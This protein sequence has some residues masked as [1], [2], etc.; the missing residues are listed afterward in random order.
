MARTIYT[1]TG[2][3]IAL[4]E[5][6]GQGGEATIYATNHAKIQAV[7][8][9]RAPPSSALVDKLTTLVGLASNRFLKFCAFPVVLIRDRPDGRVIGYGMQRLHA[10][11]RPLHQ[12]YG[13]RDR[14]EYFPDSNWK[15]LIHMARNL[16]QAVALL[17]EV[18][19]VVGDLNPN[20][21]LV[22][23]RGELFVV[24]V[25]S[26]QVSDAGR[27]YRCTVGM[28]D[29][30]APELISRPLDATDRA[31]AHD[32]FVLAIL[33]FHLLNLG[34]HPFQ[35]RWASAEEFSFELAIGDHRYVYGTEA[36]RRGFA[37]PPLTLNVQRMGATCAQL[38]ERAFV[39]H[40]QTRPSAKEWVTVLEAMRDNT[41]VCARA[42]THLYLDDAL[43]CPWCELESAG[44]YL[45][46]YVAAAAQ[47]AQLDVDQL[48]REIC[49][50]PPPMPAV[51]VIVPRQQPDADAHR[52]AAARRSARIFTFILVALTLNVAVAYSVLASVLTA[53]VVNLMLLLGGLMSL[54]SFRSMPTT[55]KLEDALRQSVQQRDQ[56]IARSDS[57]TVGQFEAKRLE[58]KLLCDVLRNF[59]TRRAGE[60]ARLNA[61]AHELQLLEFLDR[62]QILTAGIPRLNLARMAILLGNGVDTAKEVSYERLVNLRAI[63]PAIAQQLVEWR[64]A[65][66]AR[67]VFDAAGGAPRDQISAL[68]ADLYLE[69]NRVV[70][71]IKRGIG[72]LEK[73]AHDADQLRAMTTEAIATASALAEKARVNLAVAR[74]ARVGPR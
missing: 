63:G 13:P 5:V 40:I 38:F 37:P 23:P 9:Y 73:M 18:G 30:L 6:L 64:A 26:F 20:N 47:A 34:R 16:A 29:F 8:V 21:I 69:A 62:Q 42:T 33:I 24:D 22:G 60:L 57:H 59:P 10:S 61:R 32:D 4:G 71:Q 44:A 43:P 39:G 65:C 31:P 25:D 67:F 14:K 51:A 15:F 7:K 56:L 72:E 3:P 11:L 12:L 19:I 50:I 48:W 36:Q 27:M 45:F 66:E 28:P 53:Q 74:G 2:K 70:A 35:G 1:Q 52:L 17:H 54:V 49:D 58:L 46:N 41:C 55:R 68:D